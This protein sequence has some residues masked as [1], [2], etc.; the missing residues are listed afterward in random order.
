MGLP[1]PRW[2]SVDIA[3]DQ[4]A[5]VA[6]CAWR[7]RARRDSVTT[8]AQAD[9]WQQSRMLRLGLEGQFP[10]S[11]H[12]M[13]APQRRRIAGQFM[14][15]FEPASPAHGSRPCDGMADADRGAR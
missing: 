2:F 6:C 11:F 5:L 4:A 12:D 1:S 14:R 7:E 15:A 9:A 8:E 13:N 3:N 10:L